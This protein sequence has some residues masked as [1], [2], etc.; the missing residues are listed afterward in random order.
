MRSTS[1][2]MGQVEA[3]KW[4]RLWR[5]WGGGI[6]PTHFLGLT[7]LVGLAEAG[8][9]TSKGETTMATDVVKQIRKAARRQFTS[10]KKSG[11]CLRDCEENHPYRNSAANMAY[12]GPSTTNGPRTFS[13]LARMD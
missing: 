7:V 10:E 3:R 5:K 4:E 8:H 13:T 12:R 2:E 9:G 11:L 1:A 6:P